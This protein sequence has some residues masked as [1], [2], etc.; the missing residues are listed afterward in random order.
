MLIR[1]ET[2]MSK[3]DK[4]SR[5]RIQQWTKKLSGIQCNDIW[6]RNRN[7]YARLL[8]SSMDAER[9]IE[10]FRKMPLQGSLPNLKEH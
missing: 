3:F 2:L 4:H 1:I 6:K 9:L 5:I 8:L 10:P 7:S